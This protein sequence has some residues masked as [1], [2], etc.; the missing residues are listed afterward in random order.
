MA[1]G[2]TNGDTVVENV[3]DA[4]CTED[5]SYDNVIY[6]SVCDAE[7]SRDT[8]TVD[9]LGHNYEATVTAPTCT[10]AGYTTYTCDCGDTYRDDEVEALG[11]TE[12]VIPAV[13]P[14]CTAVGHTEGTKCSVC[15]E[16]L[17]PQTEI[18]MIAHSY[19]ALVTAPTCTEEGNTTFTCVCGDYYIKDIV[20]ALGHNFVDG[21]CACG[22]LEEPNVFIRIWNIIVRI[23]V[24]IIEIIK[25]LFVKI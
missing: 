1:L 8:I 22:E 14:T 15:D 3:V 6:C 20:P 19:E 9:A 10:E 25:G 4:T 13:D 16:V 7:V 12:E 2:H 24:L 5:G 17:V 18:P 23:F 21:E 11:H